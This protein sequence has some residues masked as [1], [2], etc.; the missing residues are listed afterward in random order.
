MKSENIMKC[1]RCNHIFNIADA[2]I[3]YRSYGNIK[4]REKKCPVC[5]GN[6]RAFDVPQDLDKYLYVDNDERYYSYKDKGEI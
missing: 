3:C 4:I 6:F 2:T 1:N 5:G